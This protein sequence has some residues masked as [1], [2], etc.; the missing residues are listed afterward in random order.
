MPLYY[1]NASPQQGS[2]NSITNTAT[3]LRLRDF[4]LTRNIQNPI[5]YPQ[6]STSINGSPRGGQPF[7]DTSQ[8]NDTVIQQ[9]SIEVDGIFRYGNAISN[10]LFKDTSQIAGQLINIEDITTQ[11]IYPTP[12]SGTISYDQED[13]TKYGI[14]AKSD[15]ANFKKLST[16]F[17]LYVDYQ[18]QVDAGD[19]ISLRPMPF[20]T[21]IGSYN[22]VYGGLLGDGEISIQPSS[23]SDTVLNAA[24]NAF[25]NAVPQ[26]D[27]IGA[28]A[29]RSLGTSNTSIDTKLGV[30]A[31]QQLALS[32]T[33]NAAFN[34]Q[35]SL[36]NA[37][38]VNDNTLNLVKGNG[39][40][41][42]KPDY[43]ITVPSSVGP[44]LLSYMDTVLGFYTPTSY[45]DNSASIFS[46]ENGNL[47]NIERANNMILNTG[48]GQIKVLQDLMNNNL[49]GTSNYDNP[50][51]TAFRSGY[52]PGFQGTNG[53]LINPYLYAFY[54]IDGSV[55]DVLNAP[56]G[57]VIPTIS[58]NRTKQTLS[59][60][61]DDFN[62]NTYEVSSVVPF[63]VRFSW[64]STDGNTVNANSNSSEY[65]G[66]TNVIGT[67][68]VSK[69]S[70]LNKTQAL[71]N[72]IGMKTIVSSNGDT[73]IG[74]AYDPIQTG[75]EQGALSKG[76]AVLSSNNF[77]IN[78]TIIPNTGMSADN[79]FC[80]TWTSFNRYDS[81]NKL[82][83][84][85]GLNQ[86]ENTDGALILDNPW[87]LNYRNGSVLDDNGFVKIAPYIDDDLSRASDNPKK[88]MF[89]IENLAWV[90]N[91]AVNLPKVEQGPGDLLTGKFGRIMWFPPYDLSFNETS[92]VSIESNLFIGRGE[93]LYTYNNTE[94]TGNLSFKVIV[95]HPSIMNAFG[96]DSKNTATDEFIDSWLSGCLDLDNSKWSNLLTQENID[97]INNRA[98]LNVNKTTVTA[99][100]INIKSDVNPNGFNIYFGNDCVYVNS[101]YEGNANISDYSSDFE[102]TYQLQTNGS[103]TKIN[104]KYT[105]P[106]AAGT[107][108]K[109]NSINQKITIDTNT[110]DGWVTPDFQ[111]HLISYLASP[112]FENYTIAITVAGFASSQGC[113]DQNI[114]LAKQ[115][116]DNT[117]T[118]LK[119]LLAEF[120]DRIIYKGAEVNDSSIG[121][122][123]KGYSND[124]KKT[125]QSELLPKKDRY[126]SISFSIDQSKTKIDNPVETSNNNTNTNNNANSV[127]L[128]S[129]IRQRFYNEALF[130]EKLKRTD[131]FVFDKIREKIKYFHPA[132]HS[133]TPEGFNSRLTFLLQCTRQGPTIQEATPSNLAF[134][135]PPVC[136]LRIGDFYNTKIMID[137]VNFDFQEP[138]WDLNPEGIG[139]QPM[140]ANV[141]MSFKYIGGSSLLSPINKLQNALSF[142]FFA[143]TQVYDPRSDYVARTSNVNATNNNNNFA[144]KRNTIGTTSLENNYGLVLGLDPTTTSYE[145]DSKIVPTN[146]TN[147][148]VVVNQTATAAA[149]NKTET[150]TLTGSTQDASVLYM[151]VSQIYFTLSSGISGLTY[152][153]VNNS[154]NNL[155]QSYS[156]TTQ[157][158]DQNKTVVF[159]QPTTTY[160]GYAQKNTIVFAPLSNFTPVLPIQIISDSNNYF[161]NV[162]LTGVKDNSI[163]NLKANINKIFK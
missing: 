154:I 126:A 60:G 38:S 47:A 13:L 18:Q 158:F 58:Y 130:F 145:K 51:N 56:N 75:I 49:F 27:L 120:G 77:T 93:P 11:P 68:P 79:I 50:A 17:N 25:N 20:N 44:Q 41:A 69:K 40:S 34:I 81:V 72:S 132:F 7:T 73:S 114:I 70:L 76:S 96:I 15:Y 108:F 92:N 128:N 95:D 87:R 66:D 63:P 90:G 29:G 101:D 19:S 118:Y 133:M 8:G 129:S 111:D 71:F 2:A 53:P 48:Q 153:I 160:I 104:G 88:Y 46:S 122:N 163:I 5:V 141:N 85:R 83:R 156:V 61:F 64:T 119:F 4:L 74:S 32:L 35:Q 91:P 155:S 57:D 3:N 54:S 84:S 6:L 99:P 131:P 123:N 162:V 39:L 21:Q 113:P 67:Q 147:D 136:I 36:L 107:N 148:G 80:R 1:N 102:I 105:G 140:I 115:R 37:L 33:Y 65:V 116:R 161:L 143:N 112:Q 124:P 134:G 9:V 100:T 146:T 152:N 103:C 121:Q 23:I 127:S 16:S 138:Q 14:L 28:L 137:S 157:V 30:I 86:A 151:P 10:N 125:P 43:T 117:I 106:W 62:D 144:D 159:N 12:Q 42:L 78:G 110:F 97:F 94:R 26:F 82:I 149:S 55:I 150:T 59:Y 24:A 135:P 31:G 45:L 22:S 52:A 89:S 98:P 109:L 139:V 142:N